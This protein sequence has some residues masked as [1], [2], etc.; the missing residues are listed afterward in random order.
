MSTNTA[1]AAFAFTR[2]EQGRVALVPF[3]IRIDALATYTSEFLA[4]AWHVAQFNPAPI[5]N[6]EAADLAEAIGREIITRWL[7]EQRPPLWNHQ[8]RHCAIQPLDELAAMKAAK[9]A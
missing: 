8:G 2:T 9:A 4:A 7:K 3:E 1:S 6:R 5:T